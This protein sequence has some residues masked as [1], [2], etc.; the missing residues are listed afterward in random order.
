MN[1]SETQVYTTVSRAT[2]LWWTLDRCMAALQ[3]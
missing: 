1:E 2:V 3:W